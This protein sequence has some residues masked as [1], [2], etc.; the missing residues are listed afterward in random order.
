MTIVQSN[1]TE[2]RCGPDGAILM[3]VNLSVV[4]GRCGHGGMVLA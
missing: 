1:S 4:V 3:L 2:R